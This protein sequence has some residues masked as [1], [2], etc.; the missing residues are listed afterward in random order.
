VD[1]IHT[2]IITD[3]A[4]AEYP[5]LEKWVNDRAEF[6]TEIHGDYGFHIARVSDLFNTPIFN[7]VEKAVGD[8]I[9][10]K[11]SFLRL[12][13]TKLDS[14][15]R[16]HSDDMMGAKY[17]WVFYFTDPPEA[18]GEYGT[19]FFSHRTHGKQFSCGSDPLEANRLIIEDSWDLSKW[20][21]HKVCN[22]KKNRLLIYSTSLF[23]CR[24][25]FRGWGSDKT[26]GRVVSVGFFDIVK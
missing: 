21:M 13:T 16:I 11:Y 18:E 15:V 26:N 3:N 22:M 10:V 14:G 5:M 4:S 7:S 20:E 19:A 8:K 2:P 17:A 6:K 25:P 1:D 12:S 24:Y 23:H 9:D